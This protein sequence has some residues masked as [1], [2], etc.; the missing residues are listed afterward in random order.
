MRL[1]KTESAGI[2]TLRS[3]K[4]PAAPS[5]KITKLG[6]IGGYAVAEE[7]I[8]THAMSS[9]ITVTRLKAPGRTS[10]VVMRV[11]SLA[12]HDIHEQTDLSLTEIGELFGGR[13]HSTVIKSLK[14]VEDWKEQ[15]AQG[16]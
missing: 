3:V 15:P 11:R 7:I 1:S 13:D 10:N 9:G 4:K 12:M 2:T 16:D 8:R 5:I 14:R 6:D